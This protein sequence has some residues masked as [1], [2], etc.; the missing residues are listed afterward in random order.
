MKIL[1]KYKRILISVV[2]IGIAALLSIYLAILFYASTSKPVKSDVM[3]VLGCQIR[4]ETPSLMLE[5]RLEKALELYKN[6]YAGNIIVSGGQGKDEITSESNVMKMWLVSHGVDSSKII[7]ESRSTSTFE[8]LSFS[9]KLMEENKL[10]TAIIVTNDFHVFRSLMVA[11]RLEIKASAATAPTVWYLKLRY[12]AR[13]ILSVIKS[14][15][16]DR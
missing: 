6:N 3:I 14:F 10:K 11:H 2:L 4:Q 16:V 9:K 13:E 8:N 5:Y 7:E 12:H 15:L 1:K